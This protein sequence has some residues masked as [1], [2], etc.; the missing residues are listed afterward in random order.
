MWVTVQYVL[1]PSHCLITICCM[2]FVLCYVIINC[3][4]RFNLFVLCSFSCFVRFTFY[5]VCSVFL[6]FLCIASP[7]LFSICVQFYTIVYNFTDRCH[8]VET[9]LLLINIIIIMEWVGHALR[10]KSESTKILLKNLTGYLH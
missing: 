4:M 10:V 8:R 5:F 1:L 6:Y 9:Q 3:L 2:S 7:L